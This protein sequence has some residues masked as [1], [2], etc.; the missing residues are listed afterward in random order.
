MR[1]IELRLNGRTAIA[2]EA[3]FTRTRDHRNLSG[4]P[5]APF[6]DMRLHVDEEEIPVIVEANLIGLIQS[7]DEG[8]Q[9]FGGAIEAIDLVIVDGTDVERAIRSFD[10]PVRVIDLY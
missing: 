10:E 3:C 6:D 1:L 5:V 4:T 9:L 2:G 7:I 8:G